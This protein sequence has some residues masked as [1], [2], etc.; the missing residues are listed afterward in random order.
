M[1][2]RIYFSKQFKR[3]AL[4]EYSTGK[5]PD[6]VLKSLGYKYITDD[7]KY[8][9]KLIFKWRKEFYDNLKLYPLLNKDF[10]ENLL[11][12]EMNL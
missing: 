4:I 2:N 5:S 1:K 9:S 11:K 6:E 7:K 10:N 3:A 12:F 8:A